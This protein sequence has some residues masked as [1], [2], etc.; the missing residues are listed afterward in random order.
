M[1]RFPHRRSL[2]SSEALSTWKISEKELDT[3][4]FRNLNNRKNIIEGPANLE[5]GDGTSVYVIN[6]WDGYGA[7][8]AS[9]LSNLITV[10]KLFG[11]KF[12]IGTPNVNFGVFF[13]EKDLPVVSNFIS[14]FYNT[15]AFTKLY[16]KYIT[17]DPLKYVQL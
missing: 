3:I 4:A 5:N 2:I 6:T 15:S 13:T 16:D 7:V 11:E 14:K 1:S 10:Q 9:S 8:R 17:I 12:Y